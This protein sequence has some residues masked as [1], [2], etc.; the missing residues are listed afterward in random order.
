MDWTM[1]DSMDK[2]AEGAN[3]AFVKQE[4]KRTTR[5][6]LAEPFQESGCQCRGWKY[7]VS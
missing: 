3:T 4:R 7:R 2:T 5:C 1:K 6:L